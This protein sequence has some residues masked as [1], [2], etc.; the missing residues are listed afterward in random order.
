M[1]LFKEVGEGSYKKTVLQ[2][3]YHIKEANAVFVT[4]VTVIV[5]AGHTVF[6]GCERISKDSYIYFTL[7][8]PTNTFLLF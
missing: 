5:T 2:M 4:K 7:L 1:R 3:L 8:H 6:V